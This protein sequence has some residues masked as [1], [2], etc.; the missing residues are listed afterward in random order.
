M[1]AVDEVVDHAAVERAR[2]VERAGGD[3]VLEAVGLELLEISLKPLDSSW[4]TPV[5]VAARDERRRRPASSTRIWSMS[6]S[7]GFLFVGWIIDL[8]RVL[9]DG[10]RLQAEEVEL[11]QA[12]LLDLVLG[13]LRDE[14]RLLAA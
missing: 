11:H 2:P 3:D 7:L 6:N 14:F 12:G 8:H 13:E 4:N 10:Q 1:L 5:G 9:D